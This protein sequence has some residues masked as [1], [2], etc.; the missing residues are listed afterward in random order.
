MAVVSQTITHLTRCQRRAS[1]CPIK[2]I[3]SGSALCL[4]LIR[5]KKFFLSDAGVDNGIIWMAKVKHYSFN[6]TAG[7]FFTFPVRFNI[8]QPCSSPL[9]AFLKDL[10]RI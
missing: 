8:P 10:K 9:S 6:Q 1:I 3:S 7:S 4:F 5:L 2:D